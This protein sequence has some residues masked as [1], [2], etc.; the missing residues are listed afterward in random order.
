MVKETRSGG[1][2][3]KEPKY[4]FKWTKT[5]KKLKLQIA[6]GYVEGFSVDPVNRDRGDGLGE[7]DYSYIGRYHCASGYK[8]TTGVAGKHHEKPG[9]Q[10]YS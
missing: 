5:G 7:L 9:A 6:D 3:V 4:W 1:V 8:S 2:E 10:R